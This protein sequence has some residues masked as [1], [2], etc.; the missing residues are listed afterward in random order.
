MAV[1]DEYIEEVLLTEQ[2]IQQRVAELGAQISAD[3]RDADRL[4]LVCIL[5]G[6][7]VF[8]SDLMRHITI[9]TAIDFMAVSSY[10]VGARTSTGVVRIMMDLK[11]NIE[12]KHV[13]IVEDII[14]TGHTLRYI[15]RMLGG[16]NPASLKV[17]C[18]LSKPERREAEVPVDYI[19]F[20]IPDRYVFGYGLDVDELWRHLPFLAVLRKG[21]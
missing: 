6:A 16:R 14:D 5:R 13:L 9:P 4:L 21:K 12:N 20:E 7:V 3:Y 17:A 18:F 2:Q 11:T 19:G 10:G 15:T 1:Y 8:L